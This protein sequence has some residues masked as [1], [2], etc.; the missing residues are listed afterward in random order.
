[1]IRHNEVR[2]FCHKFGVKTGEVKKTNTESHPY[3]ELET[4]VD[5]GKWILGLRQGVKLVIRNM[6]P[7]NIVE[8]TSHSTLPK[9]YT[10]IGRLLRARLGGDLRAIRLET[11]PGIF[12]DYLLLLCRDKDNISIEVRHQD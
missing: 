1:M 11:S 9:N 7:R 10:D 5:A 12:R 2:R 4:T 3:V 8:E 6:P